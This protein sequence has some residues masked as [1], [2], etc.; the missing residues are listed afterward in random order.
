MTIAQL[1]C[2]QDS[3]RLPS[4]IY[5]GG[6]D[7]VRIKKLQQLLFSNTVIKEELWCKCIA[8]GIFRSHRKNLIIFRKS[9]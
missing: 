5:L 3:W 7:Y 2:D 8:Y 9:M 4:V 1:G 6:F